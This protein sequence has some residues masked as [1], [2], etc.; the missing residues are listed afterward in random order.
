MIDRAIALLVEA[1]AILEGCNQTGRASL[2]RVMVAGLRE[3]C[4]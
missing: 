1:A 3:V 4:Q 2:L